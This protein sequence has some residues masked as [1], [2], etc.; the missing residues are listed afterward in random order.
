MELETLL[1]LLSFQQKEEENPHSMWEKWEYV[2]SN[3]G[4][5]E[6]ILQVRGAPLTSSL[7]WCVLDYAPE[8]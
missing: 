3:K 4:I 5:A 7:S 1:E 8:Y 2:F 6:T